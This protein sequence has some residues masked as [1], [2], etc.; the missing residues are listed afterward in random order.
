[1]DGTNKTRGPGST[2]DNLIL[3]IGYRALSAGAARLTQTAGCSDQLQ[4][5]WDLTPER[6]LSGLEKSPA[7]IDRRVLVGSGRTSNER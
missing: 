4:D 1:M 6:R 2:S 5:E 7:V 3:W